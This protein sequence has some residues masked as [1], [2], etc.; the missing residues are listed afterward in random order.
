[1]YRLLFALGDG[2]DAKTG[3][4]LDVSHC[5][6]FVDQLRFEMQV[7]R[8]A[9]RVTTRWKGAK[10]GLAKVPYGNAPSSGVDQQ[11]FDEF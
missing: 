11:E 3:G 8:D 7:T 1:T 6:E 4:L 5:E 9:D 2:L 10:V